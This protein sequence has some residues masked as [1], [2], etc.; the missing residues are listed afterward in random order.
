MDSSYSCRLERQ[1]GVYSLLKYANVYRLYQEVVAGKAYNT[2]MADYIMPTD[3]ERV[4][5]IDLTG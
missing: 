1:R 3:G 4:L 5:D 2:Y